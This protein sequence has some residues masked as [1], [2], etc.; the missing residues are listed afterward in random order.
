MHY[1]AKGLRLIIPAVS[2][3]NEI[4]D[5]HE[6]SV[7]GTL[8]TRKSGRD[9]VIAHPHEIT[10]TEICVAQVPEILDERFSDS[11]IARLEQLTGGQISEA[12]SPQR[13]DEIRGHAVVTQLL[14]IVEGKISV[15]GVGETSD[16]L[17]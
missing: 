12:E 6:P 15:S 14:E 5:A 16:E 3:T 1:P 11:V 7:R 9:S 17:A 10:E 13:R 8:L 4:L 2:A